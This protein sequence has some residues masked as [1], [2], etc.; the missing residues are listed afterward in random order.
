MASRCSRCLLAAGRHYRSIVSTPRLGT[1]AGMLARMGFANP[2][3]AE[4]LISA[5]LDLDLA[6]ATG[7]PFTTAARHVIDTRDVIEGADAEL[8]AV[9]AA[10]ADPD[11]ALGAIAAIA[12]RCG[13]VGGAEL[14]TALRGEPEPLPGLAAVLGA[15]PANG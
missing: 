5:E 8:L 6:P 11:L 7:M 2:K 13:P 10:A 3:R 14:R 12:E 4:H 1:L 15:R 9:L